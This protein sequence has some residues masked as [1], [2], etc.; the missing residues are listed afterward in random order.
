[1]AAAAATDHSSDKQSSI[2]DS[3]RRSKRPS[4]RY[5][6]GDD[7]SN[8]YDDNDHHHHRGGD[9]DDAEEYDMYAPRTRRRMDPFR[10]ARQNESVMS[11]QLERS[12]HNHH[13]HQQQHHIATKPKI[14]SAPSIT[15]RPEDPLDSWDNA[16]FFMYRRPWL[17]ASVW[18][19]GACFLSMV[20]G[21]ALRRHSND[22]VWMWSNAAVLFKISTVASLVYYTFVYSF[23]PTRTLHTHTH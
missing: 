5:D 15:V 11:L 18:G 21:V 8:E 12:H 16:Y 13:H 3:K 10:Q 2:V 20:A 19:L 4:L 14:M 23:V 17:T 6:Y 1:M 22:V 9:D 7:M